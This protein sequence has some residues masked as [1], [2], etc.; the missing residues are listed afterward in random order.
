[1]CG[2]DLREMEGSA[3]SS[4]E[5]TVSEDFAA[6]APF[7][8]LAFGTSTLVFPWKATF[9]LFKSLLLSK[10]MWIRPQWP[11]NW[12]G[13]MS[14]TQ[15][16]GV[17]KIFSKLRN[18]GSYDLR[19]FTKFVHELLSP[20][21]VIPRLSIIEL[22][23]FSLLL[24]KAGMPRQMVEALCY[25]EP[26]KKSIKGASLFE[27]RPPTLFSNEDVA[28][29]LDV[30]TETVL[31]LI[32]AGVLQTPTRAAPGFDIDQVLHAQEFISGNLIKL[33]ELV[34]LVGFPLDSQDKYMSTLL[35]PWNPRHSTDFR[36]R[37]EHLKDI[38][39]ILMSRMSDQNQTC[40]TWRLGDLAR[41]EEHPFHLVA[42]GV[43]LVLSGTIQPVAWRPP[44][45]WSDL[46]FNKEDRELVLGH[47]ETSSLADWPPLVQE[48]ACSTPIIFGVL[49]NG[50]IVC[51][52]GIESNG[53]E[54]YK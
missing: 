54:R 39:L 53:A 7:R 9:R 10:H 47:P 37:V 18:E 12:V 30:D 36:V 3:A 20:L 27:G 38:Q 13:T 8:F 6:L 19:V 32:D 26:P 49:A 5:C 40:A 4:T 48:G 33:T 16:H 31:G 1:T 17:T 46:I 44:H 11:N 29:F 24:S 25:L 45:A 22:H 14:V 52:D 21:R 28:D 42:T 43:A 50:K 35:P 41:H 2:Y 23:S 34:E 51:M 15:R